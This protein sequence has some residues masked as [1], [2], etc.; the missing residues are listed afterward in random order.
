MNIT[1]SA[2]YYCPFA[3]QSFHI[4]KMEKGVSLLALTTVRAKM[5]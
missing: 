1:L 2:T 3:A 4:N 5:K